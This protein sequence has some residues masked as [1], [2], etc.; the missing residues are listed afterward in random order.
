MIT[1]GQLYIYRNN[2]VRILNLCEEYN[3]ILFLDIQTN[4]YG[5]CTNYMSTMFYELTDEN[6]LRFL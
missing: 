1:V 6:K 4:E 2:V 3:Y 5:A